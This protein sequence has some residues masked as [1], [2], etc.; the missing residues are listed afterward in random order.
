MAVKK[1]EKEFVLSDSTVN[2]YGFRLMTS[3][4]QLAEYQRNPIGYHMHDREGGVLVRWEDLRVDGDKVMGKPVINM[5]H[6]RA[7]QT[8]AE[9]EDGFLNAASVGHIVAL[10]FSEDPSLRLAGQVGPT[11]TKWY[12]RETSLVDIPGNYNA[13]A[14]LYDKDQNEINLSDFTKTPKLMQNLVLTAL[15]LS[16]LNLAATATEADVTNKLNDLAAKAAKADLLQTELNNLKAATI[17]SQ[18]NDILATALASKKVT[19]ELSDKLAVDYADKPT[20]LKALIDALPSYQSISSQL[21][22]TKPD[23]SADILKKSW[24]ELAETGELENLKANYPEV[25]KEKYKKEF[26]TEPGL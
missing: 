10:E 3:G 17:K 16:L 24:D 1:I 23:L 7:A 13:I 6:P 18:V 19:K 11:V 20:E 22:G 12:N 2:C 4:Y 8:V 25:F 14:K 15:Q 9:I 26:G 5:S 21:S